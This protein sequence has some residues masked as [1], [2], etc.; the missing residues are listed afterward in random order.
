MKKI[1]IKVFLFDGNQLIY[2]VKTKFE[3]CY[4]IPE[5]F[6][7]LG[8]IINNIIMNIFT[9]TALIDKI[10]FNKNLFT[11]ITDGNVLMY[12]GPLQYYMQEKA[13]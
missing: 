1:N 11:K 7:S 4:D 6:M 9:S 3:V 12:K 10:K 8:W 13:T 2:P 5:C